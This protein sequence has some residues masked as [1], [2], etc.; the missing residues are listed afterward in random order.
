MKLSKEQNMENTNYTLDQALDLRLLMTVRL[1]N[2]TLTQIMVI[3]FWKRMKTK[4]MEIN[5]IQMKKMTSH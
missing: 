3:Q 4:T 2:Y 5:L 1:N